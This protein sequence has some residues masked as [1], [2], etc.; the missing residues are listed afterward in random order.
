MGSLFRA[1]DVLFDINNFVYLVLPVLCVGI[2]YMWKPS[3]I[4]KEESIDGAF[5]TKVLSVKLLV[6]YG[7]GISV[8][9]SVIIFTY[10]YKK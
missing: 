3:F 1:V 4:M 7:L 2:L 10:L 5:P 9:L 8:I 6:I